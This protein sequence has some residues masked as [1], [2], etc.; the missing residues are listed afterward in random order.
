M[1]AVSMLSNVTAYGV[2]DCPVLFYEPEDTAASFQEV[3]HCT[4]GQI[5][6][7]APKLPA[8]GLFWARS[9]GRLLVSYR[10]ALLHAY[11][12]RELT[13]SLFRAIWV[14]SK[15]E[16]ESGSAAFDTLAR[17]YAM[18]SFLREII[19]PEGSASDELLPGEACFDGIAAIR[20]W[21]EDD[22]QPVYAAPSLAEEVFGPE[23]SVAEGLLPGEVSSD[24]IMAR[25]ARYETKYQMSSE[26]F[27]RQVREGTAPDTF[28]TVAWNILLR[29]L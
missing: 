1:S 8:A 26:E 15:V 27:Q 28:D 12:Q 3:A 2:A 20:R 18:S 13:S 7:A 16:G 4:L 10:W 5:L 14:R 17:A 24:E 6:T 23:D 19:A 29:N 11:T 25:I 9:S 22:A 21:Y